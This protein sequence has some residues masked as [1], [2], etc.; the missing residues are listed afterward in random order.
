MNAVVGE[1]RTDLDMLKNYGSKWAVLASMRLDMAKQG[2]RVG[3]D[4][5]EHFRLARIKI[6]SGCFS[7]CEVGCALSRIEG[8]LI[9]IGY[10]LGEGYLQQWSDLLA[11]TAR[12]QIDLHQAGKIPALKPFEMDC[13]FLAC[14]CAQG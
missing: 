4:L 14:G 8:Q 5:D 3:R 9:S 13:T 7:P 10:P 6:L 1:R 2:I 12:G 11:Q